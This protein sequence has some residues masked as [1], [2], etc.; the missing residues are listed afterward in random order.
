MRSAGAGASAGG[1]GA[2]TSAVELESARLHDKQEHLN[3]ALVDYH[4]AE[5]ARREADREA[6]DACKAQRRIVSK[7]QELAEWIKSLRLRHLR[8]Q[9]HPGR[10]GPGAGARLR[11][12]L[13][14]TAKRAKELGALES[15]AHADSDRLMST[16]R[17]ESRSTRTRVSTRGPGPSD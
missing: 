12:N 11:Y 5:W 17:T 1:A 10:V 15:R 8:L 9:M 4:A 3:E 14:L 13:H 7:I 2:G 6:A 16:T